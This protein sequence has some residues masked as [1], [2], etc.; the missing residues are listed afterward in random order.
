[1]SGDWRGP[2]ARS[3]SRLGRL[4]ERRKLPPKNIIEIICGQLFKKIN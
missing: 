1:M 3:L 4:G 2:K